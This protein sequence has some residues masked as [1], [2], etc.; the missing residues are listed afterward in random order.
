MQT[1]TQHQYHISSW[2][3]A[4]P[5]AALGRDLCVDLVLKRWK[6]LIFQ[7]VST[8]DPVR[9]VIKLESLAQ[10]KQAF[11]QKSKASFRSR[12]CCWPRCCTAHSCGLSAWRR[13][14]SYDV[15]AKRARLTLAVACVWGWGG[16]HTCADVYEIDRDGLWGWQRDGWKGVHTYPHGEWGIW[17]NTWH[18]HAK[19]GEEEGGM[20]GAH[21][22]SWEEVNR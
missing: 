1:P 16:G 21:A 6:K 10:N 5:P 18:R 9:E 20:R 4:R 8:F 14:F 22:P 19:M 15:A 2:S 11:Q 13:W 3:H 17:T 7:P 12:S